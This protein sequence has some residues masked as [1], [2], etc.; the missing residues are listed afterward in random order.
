M[1]SETPETPAAGSEPAK[2]KSN[3]VP[4]LIVI[5]VI[6]VVI[7]GVGVWKLTGDDTTAAPKGP[8]PPRLSKDLFNAW[9]AGNQTAAAKVATPT[10]VTKMFAVPASD[11]SGLTFGGC[12]KIG[13]KQLPKACV[14]SRPGGQLT[15]TVNKVGNKRTITKVVYGP[16]AT[17]PTS[18][19]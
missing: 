14:Y 19:G 9:Q 1:A 5:G 16:A 7:I 3:L 11:G 6:V 4:I 15:F 17:T 8:P 2:K 12:T 13:D 10:A 18:T